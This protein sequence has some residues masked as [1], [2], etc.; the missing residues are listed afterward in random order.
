MGARRTGRVERTPGPGRAG[1][2]L[3]ETP[4]PFDV[5]E[6]SI[7]GSSLLDLARVRRWGAA[8]L[9]Y[10]VL[11]R[12]QAARELAARKRTLAAALNLAPT[13]PRP[14]AAARAP[15]TRTLRCPGCGMIVVRTTPGG[16]GRPRKCRPCGAWMVPQP[17]GAVRPV[18]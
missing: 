11:R 6:A 9:A 17:P 15:E 18:C 1:G 10:A 2:G 3:S 4:R 14:P 5:R 8:F 16:G 7:I 12:R 13:P